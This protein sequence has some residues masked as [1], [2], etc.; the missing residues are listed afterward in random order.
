MKTALLAS[1]F[2]LFTST[3]FA[4]IIVQKPTVC[5]DAAAIFTEITGKDIK[6]SPHWTGMSDTG[7]NG[8]V[9]LVN[10]KTKTWTFIQFEKSMACILA[11][12]A[13]SDFKDLRTVNP[14][15]KE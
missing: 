7:N 13:S 12:G 11:L 10:S 9:L 3:A 5:G 8:F 1:V 15:S 14:K 4:Q 6:E 2:A